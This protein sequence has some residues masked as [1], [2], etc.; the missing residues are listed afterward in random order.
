MQSNQKAEITRIVESLDN[1]GCG[2]VRPGF[3]DISAGL[4]AEI[5][6]LSIDSGVN[7][8]AVYDSFVMA[9]GMGFEDEE[10]IILSDSGLDEE[11]SL[12]PILRSISAVSEDAF[13]R[14]KFML[15]ERNK[16]WKS[17]QEY[18]RMRDTANIAIA[19]RKTRAHIFKRDGYKCKICGS[20]KNLSIDHIVS[21]LNGGSNEYS[22]LQTLCRRCNSSKGGK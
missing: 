7:A 2:I 11:K 15:E 21:V 1:Y 19:N 10:N 3:Y 6:I 22:N 17:L 5:L 12:F 16:K 18:E 4:A 20:I 13:F 9:N 14:Y 8:F